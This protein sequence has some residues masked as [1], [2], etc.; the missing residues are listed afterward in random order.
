[1]DYSNN[2]NIVIFVAVAVTI[3]Y[4]DNFFVITLICCDYQEG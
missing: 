3:V 1:M 2:V 4:F